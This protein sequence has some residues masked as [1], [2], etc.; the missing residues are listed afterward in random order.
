MIRY[1]K[2]FV[3]AAQTSSFSAAGARLGLTQSAV[4]AQIRKLEENLHCAL[5]ERMGKSVVLSARGKQLLPVAQETLRLY[6][7]MKSGKELSAAAGTLDI[8]AISTV[9]LGLLPEALQLFRQRFPHVK[10]NVIP[11]MSV[12][13]LAQID[14]RDLDF[15]IIIKPFFKLPKDLQWATLLRER[16]VAVAPENTRETSIRELFARHPFIRYNQRSYGGQLVDKFLHR[17]HLQVN[18]VLEFD[19]PAVILQ[20]IKQGLGVSII[21]FE[22]IPAEIKTGIQLF[23]LGEKNLVREIG[24]LQ[25]RS[26]APGDVIPALVEC[27][28][29]AAQNLVKASGNPSVIPRR[30]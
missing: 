13:L 7:S 30:S 5:F 19:E 24:I 3:A 1:L 21:P 4:S 14:A 8:G 10:I 26:T 2:T 25:R 22:L 12:Q 20:M 17:M 6:E 23:P 16:Y 18:D 29:A 28:S 27:L 11:G 9:Q 15:A